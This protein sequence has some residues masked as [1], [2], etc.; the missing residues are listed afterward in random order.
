MNFFHN[1]YENII[2]Y[3]SYFI[4]YNQNV[5]R[6]YG[7]HIYTEEIADFLSDLQLILSKAICEKESEQVETEICEYKNLVDL[8][9]RLCDLYSKVDTYWISNREKFDECIN[10]I[11][12]I[13]FNYDIERRILQIE[14]SIGH[15]RYMTG[16]KVEKN[17]ISRRYVDD[18]FIYIEKNISNLDFKKENEQ[19]LSHYSNISSENDWRLISYEM[20]KMKMYLKLIPDSY[21]QY[22]KKIIEMQKIYKD[23]L[24]QIVKIKLWEN[25]ISSSNTQKEA[26]LGQFEDKR[27]AYHKLYETLQEVYTDKD[28]EKN[29]LFIQGLHDVIKNAADGYIN[30][31]V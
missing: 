10:R 11:K 31:L 17:F 3:F 16:Q 28:N 29:S 19:F 23:T 21:G 5:K 25:S 6:L 20:T 7:I 22:T 30:F 8:R 18:L 2:F 4:F 15:T 26:S 27:L 12:S 24:K 13:M 1:T 14:N 9:N